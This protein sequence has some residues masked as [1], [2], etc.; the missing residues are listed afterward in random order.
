MMMR[1]M[2]MDKCCGPTEAC[3]KENG[4][5]ESNMEQVEWYSLM[6]LPKKDILRTMSSSTPSEEVT[7]HNLASIPK[8]VYKASIKYITK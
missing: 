4:R 8:R 5:E 6:E 2:A 1:D 3:M 7:S